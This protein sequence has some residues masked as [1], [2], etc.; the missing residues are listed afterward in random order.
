MGCF[1][2]IDNQETRKKIKKENDNASRLS[3]EEKSNDEKDNN[4]INII[5]KKKSVKK[6]NDQ[7]NQNDKNDNSNDIKSGEEE[8]SGKS[9]DTIHKDENNPIQKENRNDDIH[10]N[11]DEKEKYNKNKINEKI[12]NIELKI[13]LKNLEAKH[14]DIKSMIETLEEL[15]Q[16]FI[17]KSEKN[18]NVNYKDEII[19]EVYGIFHKELQFENENN[20][21]SNLK[22]KEED[23]Q[24]VK[25]ILSFIYDEYNSQFFDHLIF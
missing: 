1:D 13:L 17:D 7:N 4:I 23:I 6:I 15:C 24:N 14:A 20:D 2:A 3:N 8:I 18:P 10:E 16:T 25:D 9:L 5:I 22:N 12:L 21:E 11:E 19:K